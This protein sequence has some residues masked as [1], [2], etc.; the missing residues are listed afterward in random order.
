MGGLCGPS[1]RNDTKEP[2]VH[3]KLLI[4]ALALSMLA[5]GASWAAPKVKLKIK[6]ETFIDTAGLFGL[7]VDPDAASSEWANKSGVSS[8]A[9]RFGKPA[10]FGLA[11]AK[12]VETPVVAAA[13]ASMNGPEGKTVAASTVFGYSYRN[14]GH[15]G[16]GA[17]R[18]NVTVTNG[19][20]QATYAVG[21]G[22]AATTTESVNAHWTAKTWQPATFSFLNGEMSMPLVGSDIVSVVLVFDEG[23]EEAT[24]DNIRFD[25]LIAGGPATAR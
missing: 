19:T 15:C 3:T 6:P 13:L 12:N 5:T 23:P 4:S 16:A 25:N 14:D 11:L 18:F 21:C 9:T 17:P 24:L 1:L 8:T 10:D 22:N 20:D 7:P 2:T